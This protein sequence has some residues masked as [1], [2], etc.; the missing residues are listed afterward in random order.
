MRPASGEERTD[1][2]EI[3]EHVRFTD[4]E[5]GMDGL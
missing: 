5:G 1:A 3:D 2:P 4:A